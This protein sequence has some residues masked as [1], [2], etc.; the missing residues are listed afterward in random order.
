MMEEKGK[1]KVVLPPVSQVGIIVKDMEKTVEFCSSTFGIGPFKTR[2]VNL[3]G[4][5]FRGK[6][7]TV[8]QKIAFAQA[9]QVQIE[10]IQPLEGESPH[11]EF[12]RDKEEGPNHLGFLVDDID[13]KLT[14]LAEQGIKPIFSGNPPGVTFAYLNSDKIGGVIIELIQ[15]KSKV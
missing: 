1:G 3:E 10:L 7:T 8:K 15:W 9:G 13:K 4:V 5:M 2:E 14:W 11:T 6:P 12:L